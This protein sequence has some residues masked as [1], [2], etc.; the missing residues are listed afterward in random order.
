MAAGGSSKDHQTTGHKGSIGY[1]DRRQFSSI[2]LDTASARRLPLRT[3][4]TTPLRTI[5]RAPSSFRHLL[6]DRRRKGN[7]F[8]HDEIADL[9]RLSRGASDWCRLDIVSDKLNLFT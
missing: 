4:T 6:R 3:M 2:W 9:D 8:S 5:N 1:S 7:G